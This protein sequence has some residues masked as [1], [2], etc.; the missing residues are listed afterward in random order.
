MRAM[1]Q[2]LTKLRNREQ[3]LAV[4]NQIYK[5]GNNHEAQEEQEEV[6]ESY[7][8]KKKRSQGARN[9]TNNPGS[10]DDLDNDEDQLVNEIDSF[11]IE[12]DDI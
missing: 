5:A 11:L 1:N 10:M 2:E 7:K 4:E 9:S 6:K 8:D 12:D 3:T